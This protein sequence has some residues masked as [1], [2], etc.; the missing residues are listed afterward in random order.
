LQPHFLKKGSLIALK[1]PLNP[2]QTR[3]VSGLARS[4]L[5]LVFWKLYC[6]ESLHSQYVWQIH[7]MPSLNFP[8]NST[9]P[10]P[11]IGFVH[12]VFAQSSLD[13]KTIAS[14]L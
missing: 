1:V 3:K 10:V 8:T 14:E 11:S 5:P 7:V 6:L 9:Y 13:A 2:N 12:T 4:K